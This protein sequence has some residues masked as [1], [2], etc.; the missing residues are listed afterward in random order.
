MAAQF[1]LLRINTQGDVPMDFVNVDAPDHSLY[2]HLREVGNWGEHGEVG[3][4]NYAFYTADGRRMKYEVYFAGNGLNEKQQPN[5]RANAMAIYGMYH[6]NGTPDEKCRQFQLKEEWGCRFFVGDIIIRIKKNQPLPDVSVFGDNPLSYIMALRSE[7]C[8]ETPTRQYQNKYADWAERCNPHR[9]KTEW[10]GGMMT[11]AMLEARGY[12]DSDYS[13]FIKEGQY[14]TEE[15]KDTLNDWAKEAAY[16]S[17]GFTMS[18]QG[19]VEMPCQ[20]IFRIE[21]GE[22]FTDL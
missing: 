17:P 16:P 22:K 6:K 10:P 11:A 18:E 13:F 14:F 12:E 9:Q 21:E 1:T 20:K 5:H 8:R 15:F 3:T 2:E 19:L 4:N 7:R